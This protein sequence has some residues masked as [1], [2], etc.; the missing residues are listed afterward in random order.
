[1]ELQKQLTTQHEMRAKNL[2]RDL[3]E[4]KK[5]VDELANFRQAFTDKEIELA[6]LSALHNANKDAAKQAQLEVK[7]LQGSNEGLRKTCGEVEKEAE[8]LKGEIKAA[9]D[10]ARQLAKDAVDSQGSKTSSDKEV[11]IMHRKNTQLTLENENLKKEEARRKEL[12]ATLATVEKKLHELQT[13]SAKTAGERS[14]LTQR[15]KEVTTESRRQETQLT[16]ANGD[17][18]KEAKT[19]RDGKAVMET[20]LGEAVAKSKRLSEDL[21]TLKVATDTAKEAG[22]V[23]FAELDDKFNKSVTKYKAGK[24]TLEKANEGHVTK[25]AALT[26]Q[27]ATHASQHTA[28]V[29]KHESLTASHERISSQHKQ[30]MSDLEAQRSKHLALF[31][32]TRL[33]KEKMTTL[34]TEFEQLTKSHKGVVEAKEKLGGDLSTTKDELKTTYS[35]LCSA[36]G[37]LNAI[38]PHAAGLQTQL[39]STQADLWA[40]RQKLSETSMTTTQVSLSLLSTLCSTV[41]SLLS[42]L[43][44]LLSALFSLMSDIHD[45]D[46]GH[47]RAQQP[48]AGAGNHKGQL[49][50][51]DKRGV[52][53]EV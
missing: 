7:R 14:Q 12:S 9:K 30:G 45:Y 39:E 40:T 15:L 52:S 42:V 6:K 17:L 46:I 5:A 32:S 4:A 1:L 22:S 11:R 34:T 16:K 37:E 23:K 19:L 18:S 53:A 50:C 27:A 24:V 47:V 13:S 26:E 35:E 41:C 21:D 29:A 38:K 44:S 28:L 31:E 10:R 43:C 2:E 3:S 48:E 8:K 49:R 33:L 20:E 51:C 25:I 36:R